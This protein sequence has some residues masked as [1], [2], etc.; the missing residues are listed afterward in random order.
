MKRKV[1]A[2]LLL[3]MLV[4][5]GCGKQTKQSVKK[6]PTTQAVEMTTEEIK[7]APFEDVNILDYSKIGTITYLIIGDSFSNCEKYEVNI[8]QTYLDAIIDA[9]P[10]I[11][12]KVKYGTK[13]N[14]NKNVDLYNTEDVG[15]VTDNKEE[16]QVGTIVDW[17][18]YDGKDL[19]KMD[20]STVCDYL[21]DKY[22][23]PKT[24]DES[25]MHKM[26]VKSVEKVEP[27][28]EDEDEEE[29]EPYLRITD[30]NGFI[31]NDYVHSA[32]DYKVGK[33]VTINVIVSYKENL[34]EVT[35]PMQV[36]YDVAGDAYE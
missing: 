14:N 21:K 19:G 12:V 23:L 16:L 26:T 32:K 7:E 4:T 9:K 3:T 25:V 33:Q 10:Y 15:S 22:T 29:T 6:Q 2:V 11:K 36:T 13:V 34:D 17:E 27:D 20:L 5:S 1:I 31:F 30:E 28:T 24:D 18:F 8:D 35:N